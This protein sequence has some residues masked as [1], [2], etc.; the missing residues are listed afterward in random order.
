MNNVD[1]FFLSRYLE[2]IFIHLF[3]HM[4]VT[5]SFAV[6]GIIFNPKKMKSFKFK[7]VRQNTKDFKYKFKNNSFA[8]HL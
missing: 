1:V 8:F 2:L 4:L 3:Q 5:F 7:V 6:M